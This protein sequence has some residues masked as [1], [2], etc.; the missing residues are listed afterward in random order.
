MTFGI[1]SHR[2]Y[3]R[4]N[5]SD[6]IAKGNT[7]RQVQNSYYRQPQA[8]PLHNIVESMDLYPVPSNWAHGNRC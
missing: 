3:L 4:F 6:R 5:L 2:L 8:R 7:G 1:R